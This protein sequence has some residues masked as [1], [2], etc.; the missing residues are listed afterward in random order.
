MTVFMGIIYVALPGTFI[1]FYQSKH[2]KAT[3]EDRNPDPCRTDRCPTTVFAVVHTM[4]FMALVFLG[5]CAFGGFFPGFGVYVTGGA[6]I[7][8]NVGAA[9]LCIYLG[10]ACCMLKPHAWWAITFASIALTVTAIWTVAVAGIEPYLRI[11]GTPDEMLELYATMPMFGK[12]VSIGFF[13]LNLVLWLGYLA[14]VK[15]HFTPN[16]H[17][18]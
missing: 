4:F 5:M 13:I 18:I 16:S 1:L 14:V 12:P 15:R 11:V 8:L 7:L 3:C 17:A 9:L 10:C 6:G 2:V